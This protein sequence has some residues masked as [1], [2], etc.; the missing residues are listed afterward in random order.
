MD[1]M[2]LTHHLEKCIQHY[3]T[4]GGVEEEEKCKFAVILPSPLMCAVSQC[5]FKGGRAAAATILGNIGR[6]VVL[7]PSWGSGQ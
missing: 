3:C 2:C 1:L 5:Q 7:A 4:F 6:A